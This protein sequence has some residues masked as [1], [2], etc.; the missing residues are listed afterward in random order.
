MASLQFSLLGPLRILRDSTS[1]PVGYPQQQAMLA[2][3]LLRPGRA[4]GV[5]DLIDALWGTEPPA[6]AVSTLRTYAW[7]WRRILTADRPDQD[8]LATFGDGYRLHVPEESIDAFQV[9]RL[10]A[11][12]E[13]A[14]AQGR[15]EQAREL[16]CQ[17]LE[18]WEGEPLAAIP[19]PFAERQRQRLGELRLA[20]LEER[21]AYEL[22]LGHAARC[23]P[24]LTELTTE[25]SLRERPYG[26]LMT[27]LYQA[28]RSADALAVFRDARR[29]L[30]DELGVEPGPEL[31]G[32]HRRILE[33]DPTLVPAAPESIG[34]VGSGAE[35]DADEAP[36]QPE[37]APGPRQESTAPLP[38]PA[39]LPPPEPDF[40]G[41]E[42]LVDTLGDCL[43]QPGRSTPAVAVLVGMG[44]V[45]K[46]SL[47]LHVA[48]RVRGTFPDGQLYADLHGGDAVPSRPEIVLANFLSAL[49]VTA[50]ALPDDLESRTALF[51]SVVDGRRMLIV[52]DNVR[53]AQQLRPLLPGTECCAVVVTSR[54]RMAGLPVTLQLNVDV[55]HS[56]EANELLCR[57][58]GETRMAAEPQAALDLVEA[59]GFLPLAVRIVAARLAARPMW[60]IA[61]LRE[62]LAVESR[63]LDELRAGELAVEAVFELSYRQLTDEQAA[64]F[65]R[66]A[67]VDC[68][69]IGVA[70]AAA[71]LGTDQADA[72]DVLESLV[73]A[74]MLE[75]K[76]SGR[77][78]YHDL[79]R[80]F[81]CRKSR[82]KQPDEASVAQDRL[83]GFLLS[84]TCEAFRQ[85]APADPVSGTFT[86]SDTPGLSFADLA[87]AQQWVSVEAEEARALV[88]QVARECAAACAEDGGTAHGVRGEHEVRRL[89]QAIDLLIALSPFDVSTCYA[90]L[91]ST[92]DTLVSAAVRHRDRA[93][94]GRARFLQC[95]YALAAA[96][97]CNAEAEARAALTACREVGDTV[98]LQQVLNDLGLIAQYLS[99]YDEAIA[100]FNES[101]ALARRL[102]HRSGEMAITVN[103]ALV[104]VR[105][106][107]AAEAV[108]VC[109]EVLDGDVYARDIP[110]RA[111]A[112]YVLGLALH[113]LGNHHE[114]V[115]RFK[116][117]LDLCTRA[118]LRSRSVHARYRLAES[119]RTLGDLEQA[120][121]HAERALAQ[122]EEIASERDQGHALMVLG[123]VLFDLGRRA[124]G[125]AL[126]QRAYVLFTQLKLPDASEAATLLRASERELAGDCG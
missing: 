120:L 37:P 69:E 56:S 122:C 44:G 47:A 4:A 111:Y 14:G 96:R 74:C 51:R 7:R 95:T 119:L 57:A 11:Q 13:R 99:R 87:A 54:S 125:R 40:I 10:T 8:V 63:R 123:R 66:L 68:A 38:R 28:G 103:A 18:L 36:E 1:L 100:H 76:V 15:P 79:L 24:E 126:W 35:T 107:N 45:G 31:E 60:S 102:G 61:S 67:A 88:T 19:G 3:L 39:Q 59:C 9:T 58:I 121:P 109:R 115:A 50:D 26:L 85:A 46:T 110:G 84:T 71:M 43:R 90:E 105:A 70:A 22:A 91:V 30:I 98:V 34:L 112:L 82:G 118:N 52:L 42:R 80:A 92:A 2:T 64:A 104:Q 33:R 75:S 124:E 53:D 55:F 73:D 116:E 49:G 93:A 20:L 77:Y 32:L 81:A 94:E 83:L 17:A 5:A 48:H 101:I 113:T 25:H 21:L 12:A 114:A 108:A 41:R 23:V 117:C 6:K 86:P 78:G 16:L 72:E 106:G 29:L 27:A 62:R 89:R 97:L 65:R